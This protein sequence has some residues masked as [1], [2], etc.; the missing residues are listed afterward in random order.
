MNC[1]RWEFGDVARMKSCSM[2]AVVLWLGLAPVVYAQDTQNTQEVPRLMVEETA[3]PAHLGAEAP[4]LAIDTDV[5]S[6]NILIAGFSLGA[7]YDSRGLYNGGNASVSPYYSSDV[8]YFVQPSI[9][10]QRTFSTGAWTVSYTPGI[11]IS[12]HDP[13]DDQ[14]TNNLAG[15]INWKPNS[16]FMLH[17][18]QDYSLTNN[19]FEGVGRVDLLPG[20]GG[21]FGPNYDGVLPQT[22]RTSLVTS[23]DLTY[24]VAEHSAI[25][26]TGGFQKY[27]F[28]PLHTST[29]VSYNPF[30]NSKVING[31]V[32][33]S[34]QISTSVAA[35]VQLAYTDIYSTG[36]E[37]ART[38]AP[39]PMGFV[40]WSPGQNTVVTLYAGPQY[41]RSRQDVTIGP[42][43]VAVYLHHWYPTYGGTLA[44][45]RG[46]NA[47]NANG[48]QRVAN[49]GGVLDAV[50]AIDAGAAYRARLTRRLLAE[51][52][53]NW[54]DERGIG[55]FSSGSYFRSLWAGGGPVFELKRSLSLH[56]DVAYVHQS[57]NGL[58]LAAGNHMLIQGSLDYRFRKNLGE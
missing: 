41:A 9:G 52:R 14:Y 49:G 20:L 56:M 21:P 12:Q 32:F 51:V 55:Y 44:W 40:K 3:G 28:D 24:R 16:Y 22:Q 4:P 5:V 38:Q 43:T 46:R 19:P 57:Q 45:S 18:R 13:T 26:V 47:F 2:F 17:A 42:F 15:D 30:V 54:S 31:S 6:R 10:Y 25:G 8:R 39:A 50:K 36:A 48:M 53:G 37:V 7:V 27:S 29:G 34:Q 23:V 58:A 11:S 33:Y 35:G 1:I